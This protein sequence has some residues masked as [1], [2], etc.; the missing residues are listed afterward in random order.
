MPNK[1]EKTACKFKNGNQGCGRCEF[2]LHWLLAVIDMAKNKED[3]K[4]EQQQQALRDIANLPQPPVPDSDSAPPTRGEV[5]AKIAVKIV[6][7]VIV[8]VFCLYG[9]YDILVGVRGK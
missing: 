9:A 2:T 1:K 8:L 4:Q 7:A 3:Y 6:L 5:I